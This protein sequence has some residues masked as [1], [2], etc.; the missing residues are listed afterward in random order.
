MMSSQ[1]KTAKEA[2]DLAVTKFSYIKS[3]VEKTLQSTPNER[4]LTNKLNSLEE[5]L[6]VLNIAHATWVSKAELA[7]DQL[8]QE[9][10]S[11]EWL[12][13]EWSTVGDLQIQVEQKL[14]AS[15]V[16]TN[17]QKLT[18]CNSQME[19]LQQDIS[20]KL[21]NLLTKTKQS[22]STESSATTSTTSTTVPVQAYTKL[23]SSAKHLLLNDFTSLS[24]TILSLDA[25]RLADRVK[26]L[27][28]FRREQQAK[29]AEIELFLAEHSVDPTPTA[30]TSRVKGIEMEKSKAPCF[31][32]KTIDYPEFKRGWLTGGGRY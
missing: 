4:T 22:S 17:T 8:K 26:T 6:S 2:L 25:A 28:T 13:A 11:Q 18:V 21:D 19:S 23:L 9:R 5:A 29:I 7:Q 12:E 31:S 20:T 32:G 3:T 16:Q 14:S 30:S 24:E 10:F 1:A 27:E 15:S